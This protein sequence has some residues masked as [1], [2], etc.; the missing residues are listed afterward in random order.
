ML[1]AN[2]VELPDHVRPGDIALLHDPQ[3]AGLAAP[4]AEAGATVVWRCHIGAD[5]PT[6]VTEAAWGF[7]RP[8]LTAAH[9][10]VFSRRAYA[11]DWLDPQRV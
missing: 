8:F 4:L 9:G 1:T 2:A 7:L 10:W 6:G 5:R 3:T 11:P